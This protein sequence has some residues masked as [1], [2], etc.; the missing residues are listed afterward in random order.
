VGMK[1]SRVQAVVQELQ[2]EKID[3]IPWSP[4]TATFVVNALQPAEV[5]KVVLDEDEGRIDVVVPDDQ[6]SLAIGRRGQNV[7]LASALTGKQIDIMTEADESERR[8]KEFVEK[9]EMFQAE[10]DVD[11]TLAQLLV[12]EGFSE[13][14]EV[15]YVDLAEVASIEGFDDELATELQNRA[16]E[17]LERREAAAREERR[18]L[19][20]SDDLAGIEGLTEPMLVALGK[21]GILTLDDL[22]DLA[23]DE[24]VGKNG[25]LKDFG[26]SEED[27]NRIIMAARAHW[28]ADESAGEE[29]APAD[30]NQ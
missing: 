3:I 15:A 14:E 11:E 19:G 18:G 7:R 29:V 22:G 23:T 4:D 9:S 12:A 26:T 27:G 30:G 5:S 8:Q 10:L 6:L 17:A 28:F 2:G 25:L 20:V 21:K 24:L 1:G 16:V 13:L